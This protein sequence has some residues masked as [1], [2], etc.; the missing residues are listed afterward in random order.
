MTPTKTSNCKRDARASFAGPTGSACRG[1]DGQ[2]GNSWC[3][4]DVYELAASQCK[5]DIAKV[6]R[7]MRCS[8]STAKRV[9]DWYAQNVPHERQPTKDYEKH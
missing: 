7:L 1:F 4:C 6:I 2:C 8:Y 3:N 5:G 9:C